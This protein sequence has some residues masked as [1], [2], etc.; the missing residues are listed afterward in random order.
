MTKE[1]HK[2]TNDIREVA[3]SLLDVYDYI[4]KINLSDIANGAVIDI[5]ITIK[6]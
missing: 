1:L 3:K 2:D 5:V 6:E 4:G